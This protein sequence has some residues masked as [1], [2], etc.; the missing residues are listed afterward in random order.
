MLLA[1]KSVWVMLVLGSFLVSCGSDPVARPFVAHPASKKPVSPKPAAI[2]AAPKDHP[3]K[4]YAGKVTFNGLASGPLFH[5]RIIPENGSTLEIPGM[6]SYDQVDGFWFRGSS[7]EWFKIPD[8]S[9]AWVGNA[10]EKYDGTAHRGGLM[11]YYRSSP[12]VGL[13]GAIRGGV[14]HPAWVKDADQTKSPVP[15][16]FK[17]ESE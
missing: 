4:A 16:P 12:L 10:P 5:I 17:N 7:D 1:M 13:V 6:R 9:E 3:R 15:S 2:P 14:K 8:H 11:I